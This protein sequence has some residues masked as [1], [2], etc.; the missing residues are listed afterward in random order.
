MKGIRASLIFFVALLASFGGIGHQHTAGGYNLAFEVSQADAKTC[1]VAGDCPA[2]AAPQSTKATVLLNQTWDAT[3]IGGTHTTYCCATVVQAA[4]ASN[5]LMLLS[6]G[7]GDEFDVCRQFEFCSLATLTYT[8]TGAVWDSTYGGRATYTLSSDPGN[9]VVVGNV[10]TTAG[11]Q[12]T[13]GTGVGY[14]GNALTVVGVHSGSAPYTISVSLPALSSPGTFT[15]CGGGGQPACG[16][17]TAL[18]ITPDSVIYAWVNAFHVTLLLPQSLPPLGGTDAG[19]S[20]SFTATFAS[21]NTFTATA[22]ATGLISLPQIL[23]AS[24]L[25]GTVT[26]NGK[27]TGRGYA[28]S[29]TYSGTPQTLGPVA[30]SGNACPVAPNTQ[31]WQ[32]RNTTSCRADAPALDALSL[33]AQAKYGFAAA[34]VNVIGHSEGGGEAWELWWEYSTDFGH[35]GS[36]SMPSSLYYDAAGGNHT[37]LPSPMRSMQVIVGALDPTVCLTPADNPTCGG[38]PNKV[39][40]TISNGSGGA[41]TAMVIQSIDSGAATPG[42][43]ITT[44]A[45]VGTTITACSDATHCTVSISQLVS[46]STPMNTNNL[47]SAQIQNNSANFTFADFANPLNTVW[48]GYANV[49]ATAANGY[50]L[51]GCPAGLGSQINPADGVIANSGT[52]TQTT[53]WDYCSKYM[54]LVVVANG[55]HDMQ[56]I[57]NGMPSPQQGGL[58]PGP[59][60]LSHAVATPVP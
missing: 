35:F 2:L 16:T 47:F 7:G 55:A 59:F 22:P 41:G 3:G 56:S 8:I 19:N 24:G 54:E 5:A 49:M 29:Y 13:G 45:A 51:H 11:V 58:P 21:D 40:A 50:T 10:L 53:T 17:G 20:P 1:L 4:S 42:N 37:T 39:H 33:A 31:T 60:F 30:T 12:S 27:G 23:T 6:G 28:G 9:T 32:N 43:Q 38:T 52:T 48:P 26:V 44:G 14:N 46:S 34:A 18:T 36:V 25:T 57:T 15:P